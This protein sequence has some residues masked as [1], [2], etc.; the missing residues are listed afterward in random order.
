ML[1]GRSLCDDDQQEYCALPLWAPGTSD[2]VA[3][4]TWPVV[5]SG[6]LEPL[7]VV[8]LQVCEYLDPDPRFSDEKTPKDGHTFLR[9]EDLAWAGET[10]LSVLLTL[11]SNA[12]CLVA[13]ASHNIPLMLSWMIQRPHNMKLLESSCNCIMHISEQNEFSAFCCQSGAY[14]ISYTSPYFNHLK[15]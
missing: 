12:K 10:C 5:N 15:H 4:T 1:R 14:F 8:L 2:L 6:S 9:L 13:M 3:K 11:S 7:G